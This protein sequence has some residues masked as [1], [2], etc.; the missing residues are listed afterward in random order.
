MA[1]KI[2]LNV[3]I[4]SD[5]YSNDTMEQLRTA[6]RRGFIQ[7]VFSCADTVI[8][9]PDGPIDHCKLDIDG[10]IKTEFRA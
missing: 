8:E 10:G 4:S 6:I 5:V 9:A 7:Y 2:H 1:T 3:T